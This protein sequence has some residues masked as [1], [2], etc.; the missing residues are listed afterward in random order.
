LL[1]V[2]Q[3]A[4]SDRAVK[5]D[6]A[7][8]LVECQRDPC[9]FLTRVLGVP[10]THIWS[11]PRAIAQSVT[12]HQLTVVPAGHSVSKTW[13]A[14]RLVPWFKC[15]F[16]PS[17]VITTAPSDNQVRNQLWREIASAYQGAHIPLGGNLTGLQ[18]DMRLPERELAQLDPDQ[19][20]MFSKDFAIGFSTSPD[21]ATEHATKMQGWHNRYLLVILDEACGI[22]PQIWRT[23]MEGLI[24]NERCKVLAIGNST[25]PESD[26]ASACRLNGKLT[27]LE[28]SSEPYVSDQGWHV[29]PVSVLDT[30]NYIE[31]REV[32]P[33]VA[34]RDFEQTILNRHPKG[35][36][37]WLIRV[38]GA[39]PST[40]EGTY[41]GAEYAQAQRGQRIGHYPYD[42]TFPVYRF[43]DFGDV[44]T[45]AFD[46]QFIRGR[47][48][49][50]N[51]Y[52][53]N[54]GDAS[55]HGGTQPVDGRG[56]L[57]LAKSMQAMPYVWGQ[58]HYAGPDLEGSNKQSFTASGAT[59]RDVLRGLGRNFRAVASV[60]FDQGIEAVRMIWPL[61]DIDE[62]GAG[63]F[64]AAAKGYGKLKNER[65]ST[66]DQP[67]YHNQP[68]GTWHRHMCLVGG[69]MISTDRGQ[70]PIE[71][72]RIGD[73]VRTPDGFRRVLASGLT[74]HVTRFTRM[75]TN[76]GYVLEGTGDHPIVS[77]FSLVGMD[78]LRYRSI[79]SRNTWFRRLL[80]KTW[81]FSTDRSIG[82]RDAI[83]NVD[84]SRMA[85]KRIS[86]ELF[87]FRFMAPFRL[88][89]SFITQTATAKI[90]RHPIWSAYP[91]VGTAPCTQNLGL[92]VRATAPTLTPFGLHLSNGTEATQA[93]NGTAT[94]R[95]EVL[96]SESPKLP[97]ASVV[98]ESTVPTS[99]PARSSALITAANRLVSRLER[100]AKNALAWS[101][102]QSFRVSDSI[103]PERVAQVVQ[104]DCKASPRP[105][106]DLTVE[107]DHCFYANGVLVGNCDALRHLAVQFRFGAIG[108]EYI[109]DDR[110]IAAYMRGG[111]GD[112]RKPVNPL[113]WV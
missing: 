36:N 42:P 90:M 66:D 63:T 12:D 64:L 18:W 51:D 103:L 68:A 82:L 79:L 72:V 62:Q 107:R 16:R 41:Y 40:K 108:G 102:E 3:A 46:A 11:K 91:V 96:P 61:L 35:S 56:A 70:V 106:Y 38:R 53:D 48:R 4:A 97:F 26:F 20:E 100:I 94:M 31:G 73:R 74:A 49:V 105:V 57:G 88:A 7:A 28:T 69:T 84:G 55:S 89:V 27:H 104:V 29:V 76:S 37:G 43:A 15:C 109:G 77:G 1:V 8:K 95:A 32:V 13:L 21:S 99:Q 47:I 44:W 65:L 87:G 34:G 67:A 59:T 54:S 80:W 112:K 86:T 2:A 60:S 14:G 110:K 52:W 98:A 92:G 101:V 58:E 75:I 71:A 33:G 9:Q 22:L 10:E 85:A 25:D 81:L 93:G 23:V 45:A 30:P 111:D 83:I 17:T 50:I 113:N 39:F 24:V 19:R 78:A 5:A 6:M